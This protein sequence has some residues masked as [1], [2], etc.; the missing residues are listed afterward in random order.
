MN[1][2]PE[3]ANPATAGRASREPRRGGRPT[4]WES[5]QG[6]SHKVSV[7]INIYAAETLRHGTQVGQFTKYPTI[8]KVTLLGLAPAKLSRSAK[9]RIGPGWA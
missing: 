6:Q 2:E 1:G 8:V 7:T 9:H 5:S 3:S 4:T